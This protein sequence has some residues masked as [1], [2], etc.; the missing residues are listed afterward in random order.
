MA[1]VARG[2]T[3]LLTATPRPGRSCCL[4]SCGLMG[5]VGYRAGTGAFL[6]EQS[7]LWGLLLPADV[8]VWLRAQGH[9]GS[10][11]AQDIAWGRGGLLQGVLRLQLRQGVCASIP[12]MFWLM[13]VLVSLLNGC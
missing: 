4:E 12:G 8:T 3:V 13:W 1:P 2:C 5:F 6:W 7:C 11:S 10:G 9:V